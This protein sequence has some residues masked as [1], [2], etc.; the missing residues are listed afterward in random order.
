MRFNGTHPI[1][2]ALVTLFIAGCRSDKHMSHDQDV[3]KTAVC[4]ECYDAVTD[5]RRTHPATDENTT[6]NTYVCPCCKTEMSVYIENGVH[7]V[8]CG[9]CARDG[10]AW[11]QCRPI[12]MS[13][14]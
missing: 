3:S 2:L 13:A 12:D 1:V 7:M 9:G 10:V 14:E 4:Q 6:I 5:A 8:K 11:N